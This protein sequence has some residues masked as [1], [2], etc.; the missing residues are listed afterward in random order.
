MNI[1]SKFLKN[2]LFLLT[3]VLILGL[4]WYVCNSGLYMKA[5]Y[6]LD[7]EKVE[8]YSG[9]R[10]IA[11]VTDAEQI[12]KL[13]ESVK[14]HEWRRRWDKIEGVINCTV[15]FNEYTAIAF[16]PEYPEAM[17]GRPKAE[18]S[19]TDATPDNAS[20]IFRPSLEFLQTIRELMGKEP[21]EYFEKNPY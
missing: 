21:L 8:I 15:V 12:A 2:L 16:E 19:P 11:T 5:L 3:A 14:F 18:I 7:S 20:G 4:L 10:L 13:Q 6:N 9:D 1:K 17:V